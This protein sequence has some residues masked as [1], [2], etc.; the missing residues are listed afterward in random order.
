MNKAGIA[1]FIG[2]VV[3]G[4]QQGRLYGFPTANIN[5]EHNLSSG[6]YSGMVRLEGKVYK[7]AII[8]N[9]KKLGLVLEA[10]ILEFFGDL[11]G[12]KIT[13]TVEKFLREWIDFSNPEQGKVQIIKDLERI[14]SS[15][16][17]RKHE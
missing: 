7:S 11:Y 3:R 12:K 9:P 15:M 8:V 2:K 13:I 5:I 17:V 6:V 4:Y 14:K 1:E 10:H 16:N